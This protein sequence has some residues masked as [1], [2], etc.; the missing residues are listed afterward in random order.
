MDSDRFD[1]LT[2]SFSA[3]TTRR[4]LTR[5]LGG[6]AL[7]GLLSSLAGAAKKGGH[8]NKGGH[9]KNDGNAKKGG[10][11]KGN[12]KKGTKS[13]DG[14]KQD[15]DK[16]VSASATGGCGRPSDPCSRNNQC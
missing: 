7:S 11:G 13:N 12:G 16:T 15:N 10:K 8:H 2:R 14:H 6:L 5:L 4:S 1:A 9:Y 3:D